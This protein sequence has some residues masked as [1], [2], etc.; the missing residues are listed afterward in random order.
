MDANSVTVKIT[1]PRTAAGKTHVEPANLLYII[2]FKIRDIKPNSGSVQ[3]KPKSFHGDC[4]LFPADLY[5]R[6]HKV[7]LA[8]NELKWKRMMR[9]T[10]KKIH[11]A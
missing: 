5:L 8:D 11:T 9:K 10:T 7:S 4:Q 6:Y 2:M 1:G 3:Q